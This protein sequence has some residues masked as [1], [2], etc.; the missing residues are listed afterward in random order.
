[1]W[2]L[3][4]DLEA[5]IG[6]TGPVPANATWTVVV[7]SYSD[8][9]PYKRIYEAAS[10]NVRSKIPEVT[11]PTQMI[12]IAVLRANGK[13]IATNSWPLWVFPRPVTVTTEKP[14]VPKTD[15]IVAHH[16]DADLLDKLGMGARVLLLPDNLPGSPP[17]EPHWF[18][19]GAPVVFDHPA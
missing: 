14:E 10:P 2:P 9:E 19:R 13:D 15:V 16:L 17:L 11:S 3:D 1:F 8:E 6:V 18:L 4:R 5:T 12:L 7:G